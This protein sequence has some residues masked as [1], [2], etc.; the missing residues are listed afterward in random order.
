MNTNK[1]K[2]T[3]GQNQT[4]PR[5]PLNKLFLLLTLLVL[6]ATNAWA[7]LPGVAPAAPTAPAGSVIAL[8]NSSGT[9]TDISGIN[10]YE[11]WGGWASAAN[12]SIPPAVLGYHSVSY[13][14]I[15]FEGNVQNISAK[16]HLHVDLWTPNGSSFAIRLVS[17][18]GG[19]AD[20]TY[21]TA[22]VKLL[23]TVGS[24]WICR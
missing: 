3:Y 13:G 19:Q 15:G 24:I 4:A 7:A 17:N 21:T 5:K 22:V 11:S 10:Y 16:T 18:V 23:Q 14:G 6:A 12:Y 20:Y 9:Y 8:F 1:T 2:K